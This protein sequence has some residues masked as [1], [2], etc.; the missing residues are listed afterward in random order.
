MKWKLVSVVLLAGIFIFKSAAGKVHLQIYSMHHIF[1][2]YDLCDGHFFIGWPS[3]QSSTWMLA[4]ELFDLSISES[5]IIPS[6]ISV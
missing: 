3:S 4:S 2:I 6:T 5:L 1:H